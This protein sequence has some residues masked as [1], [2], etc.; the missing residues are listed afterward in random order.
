MLDDPKHP[1]F[2]GTVVAPALSE[3]VAVVERWFQGTGEPVVRLLPAPSSPDSTCDAPGVP[4]VGSRWLWAGYAER[5]G[6]A[7]WVGQYCSWE[8]R[9]DDPVSEEFGAARLAEVVAVFGEGWQ[10]EPLEANPDGQGIRVA[11]TPN[12][13]VVSDAAAPGS[14]QPSLQPAFLAVAAAAVIIGLFGAI[15]RVGRF[16]R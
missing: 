7:V 16:G 9:L 12:P 15:A 13:T 8:A 4:P 5:P 14:S 6:D 3:R 10:P 11:P 1:V 2:I